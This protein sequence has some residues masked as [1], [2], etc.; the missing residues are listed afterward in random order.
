[1]GESVRVLCFRLLE[2]PFQIGAF[3]DLGLYAI[4]GCCLEIAL[5]SS[6]PSK[7]RSW[8]FSV[9]CRYHIIGL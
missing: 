9:V 2:V 3:L 7:P 5:S 6:T 8:F 1:M 4:S